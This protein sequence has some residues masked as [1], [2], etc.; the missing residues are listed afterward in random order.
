[1]EMVDR[2]TK[3]ILTVIALALVTLVGQNALQQAKA[4][5]EPCGSSQDSACYVRNHDSM[6]NSLTYS[7]LEVRIKN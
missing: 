4:G 2:Y 6:G 3:V 5:R 7:P 1:M